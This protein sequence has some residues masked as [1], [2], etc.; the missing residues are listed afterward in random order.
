VIR[1]PTNAPAAPMTRRTAA[2][3]KSIRA[4][5]RCASNA[6]KDGGV[7]ARA[8]IAAA[9][10]DWFN[11]PLDS[12]QLI[13]ATMCKY[14]PVARG[15]PI[16]TFHGLYRVRPLMRECTYAAQR[17][18]CQNSPVMKRITIIASGGDAVGM[19]AVLREVVRK[20]LVDSFEV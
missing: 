3:L 2:S 19:N 8:F 9:C 4:L 11:M 16:R 20:A 5:S 7:T 17:R 1:A 6:E 18:R 15:A 14:Q 13:M 12:R 10:F